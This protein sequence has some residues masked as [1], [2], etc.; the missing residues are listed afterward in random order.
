MLKDYLEELKRA[1]Q[2]TYSPI[3]I[4]IKQRDHVD[5]LQ[6]NRVD[7]WSQGKSQEEL[8]M[9]QA[10][11]EHL[12]EEYM[13]QRGFGAVVVVRTKDAKAVGYCLW[14][15]CDLAKDNL[16]LG[17]EV[18]VSSRG[19]PSLK[20]VIHKSMG[21][22]YD[23]LNHFGPKGFTW[24]R[25][26]QPGQWLMFVM[27]GLGVIQ[28]ERKNF[29]V[30]AMLV[31]NTMLAIESQCVRQ[32]IAN[33]WGFFYTWRQEE[34]PSFYKQLGFKRLDF[35]DSTDRGKP[36]GIKTSYWLANWKKYFSNK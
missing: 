15:L 26:M 3:F 35:E 9:G 36:E 23:K 18:V 5:F 27:N 19:Q 21:N 16:N 1:G 17:G 32:D 8:G 28:E 25:Q 34:K 11:I 24:N 29:Q 31:R 4:D 13:K 7:I 20:E 22:F 30:A 10:E 12:G 2:V 33:P 6:G 14:Y